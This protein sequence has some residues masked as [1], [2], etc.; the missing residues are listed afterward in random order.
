MHVFGTHASAGE[1]G[2]VS[3][4]PPPPWSHT[5]CLI[6]L[7]LLLHL[8]RERESALQELECLLIHCSKVPCVELRDRA[9]WAFLVLNHICKQPQL[10]H[11]QQSHANNGSHPVW[12]LHPCL[13]QCSLLT[14]RSMANAVRHKSRRSGST[15]KARLDICN[16]IGFIQ[17]AF[18]YSGAS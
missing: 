6:G 17:E 7:L 8:T 5:G 16:V 4:F 3:P 14:L 13:P 15:C 1:R 11:L 12:V 10:L 18:K 2:K 9:M